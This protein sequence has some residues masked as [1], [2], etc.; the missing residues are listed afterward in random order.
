MMTVARLWPVSPM[1][2]AE[3]VL[4]SRKQ[5]TQLFDGFIMLT[6]VTMMLTVIAS[7]AVIA[8]ITSIGALEITKIV[9]AVDRRNHD[10][11]HL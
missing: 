7:I 1:M 5:A 11:D 4:R 2:M 10:A 8:G 3:R 6:I 9:G